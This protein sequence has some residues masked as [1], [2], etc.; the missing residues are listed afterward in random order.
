M[1]AP[2][3]ESVGVTDGAVTWSFREITTI[4]VLVALSGGAIGGGGAARASMPGTDMESEPIP[5]AA[6]VDHV[7]GVD[8]SA[9]FDGGH[10]MAPINMS[11]AAAATPDSR[12]N[13]SLASIVVAG[14]NEFQRTTCVTA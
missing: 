6:P 4:L 8:M 9:G 11:D 10:G 14:V 3:F 13:Q 12:V 5:S 2:P 7:V 1:N